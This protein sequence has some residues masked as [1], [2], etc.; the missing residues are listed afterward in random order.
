MAS[1]T[2]LVL[3]L[4]SPLFPVPMASSRWGH[5]VRPAVRRTQPTRVSF[6]SRHARR[7]MTV[8]LVNSRWAKMAAPK[9]DLPCF[10]LASIPFGS[11]YITRK[12]AIGTVADN[13]LY[14]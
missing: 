12:E 14:D 8:G 6:K 3:S 1:S 10:S 9:S 13:G 7:R 4:R 5:G 11:R 2:V